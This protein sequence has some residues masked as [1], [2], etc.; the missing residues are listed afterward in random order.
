MYISPTCT[1]T[2]PDTLYQFMREHSFATLIATD[3][4]QEQLPVATHLPLLLETPAVGPAR[5]LG[6]FARANPHWQCAADRSVLAVFHGPHAYISA[7][8]YGEQNVVP[9]WNY[10][11]VHASGRLTVE[12]DPGRLD[13]LVRRTVAYYESGAAQPWSADTVDPVWLQ[14]L[15]GGIVG[16][17]IRIERLEGCWKLNQHHSRSRREGAVQGLLERGGPQDLEIARLMQQHGPPRSLSSCVFL[18][19]PDCAI[20]TESGRNPKTLLFR[21]SPKNKLRGLLFRSCPC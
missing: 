18:G 10:V 20:F 15:T 11:A 19:R 1:V 16:F 12:H 3:P 9:T 6:H 14:Q 8:W 5:L 2:D 13:Q 21:P 7:G 4:A 17:E